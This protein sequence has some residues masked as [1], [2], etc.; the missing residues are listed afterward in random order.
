MHQYQV[1]PVAHHTDVRH[2]DACT[3]A[4]LAGDAHSTDTTVA[5]DIDTIPHAEDI[6]ITTFATN[7]RILACTAAQDIVT[8]TTFQKVITVTTK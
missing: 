6:N 4:D 8:L 5:N 7:Q 2:Q 1:V 3:K